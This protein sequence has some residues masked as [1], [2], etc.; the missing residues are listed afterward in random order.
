MRGEMKRT[1][2]L[3]KVTTRTL[4]NWIKM[5]KS[6][7]VSPIGRPS[8]SKEMRD[9]ARLL[10]HRE[11][12]LQG[13]PGWRPIDEALK[14][15]V[16][17]R[18]VQEY[19]REIKKDKRKTVQKQKDQNT[20][21]ATV[22]MKNV[23][24]TM[25]GTHLGRLNRKS[26]ESQVIK[27]RGSLLTLGVSTGVAA[28]GKD[29]IT[30]LNELKSKRYLPIVLSTDNGSSYCNEEVR[31]F[32]KKHKIVHLLS[33]PRTPEH[34][35]SSEI[36]M[37]ELKECAGLGKGVALDGALEAHNLMVNSAKSLS[38]RLRGSKKFNS[39]RNLDDIM[40]EASTLIDRDTF[41]E[42]CQQGLNKIRTNTCCVR[43]K[44][45]QER[46]LILGMLE[47]YGCIKQTRGTGIY[48]EKCEVFL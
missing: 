26:I 16:P 3:L 29:V 6:E 33:L 37:R 32:L 31:K 20:K 11:M 30:L 21:V 14:G 17:T 47:R 13:N 23:I 2:T 46:E 42:D 9:S 45:M 8:Y 19:V 25:D 5:Y 27:D 41:Y 44:R 1:A 36:S 38:N 48:G 12:T 18:L 22:Q 35:S 34:N 4:E 28:T 40:F 24:W 15:K 43:D 7:V 39:A 10:V